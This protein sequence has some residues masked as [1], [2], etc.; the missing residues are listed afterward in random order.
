MSSWVLPL[1]LRLARA[2][3]LL[4]GVS[5]LS[6]ALMSG[7]GADKSYE[8]AGANADAQQLQQTRV[9]LGYERPLV[10]RYVEYLGRIARLDFGHALSSGERVSNLLARAVPVSL[11]ATLPGFLLGHL[12]ALM[13]AMLAAAHA[14]TALDRVIAGAASLAMSLSLVIVVIACQSLLG[15][16]AGLGWFPVRGWDASSLPRYLQHVAVPTVALTFAGA[17]YNLRYY[18]S[19]FVG[20]LEQPYVRHAQAYGEPAASLFR[21][22]L[23][24]N[25]LPAIATRVLFSVP[26]LAVSGSLLIESY[27]GIPGIGRA[28]FEAAATGDQPVLQAVVTLGALLFALTLSLT[29]AFQRAVDPRLELR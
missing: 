23:L 12:L 7:A 24:P 28:T 13:A 6:F 16:S 15:S 11:A 4:L 3:P 18:R 9:S 26:L 17:A 19:L 29:D 8:L 1:L 27:F 10:Q 20:E 5:L 2:L 21:R 25:L 22:Q 14:G